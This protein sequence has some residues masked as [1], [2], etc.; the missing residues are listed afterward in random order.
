MHYIHQHKKLVYS[1]R[2][3]FTQRIGSRGRD[4]ESESELKLASC[5]WRAEFPKAEHAPF[6]KFLIPQVLS[7]ETHQI[8]NCRS[9]L[10][11]YSLKTLTLE[12]SRLCNSHGPCLITQSQKCC[13]VIIK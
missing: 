5:F 13:C 9:V 11:H 10:Y 3:Y 1:I 12:K 7:L 4:K 8:A 6:V 2:V